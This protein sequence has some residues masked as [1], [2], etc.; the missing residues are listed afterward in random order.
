MESFPPQ[1]RI[2]LVHD[3]LGEVCRAAFQKSLV[4]DLW[5]LAEMLGGPDAGTLILNFVDFFGEVTRIEWEVGRL[6]PDGE[7]R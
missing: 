5:P 7:R 2:I 6:G 4:F 1:A 3:D